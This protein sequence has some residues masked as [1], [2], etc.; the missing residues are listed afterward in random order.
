MDIPLDRL[1][2]ADAG[3][4]VAVVEFSGGP[5]IPIPI[6]L[7]FIHTLALS[8]RETVLARKVTPQ[9]LYVIEDLESANVKRF[10]YWP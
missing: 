2:C 8:V 10:S 1:D 5:K 4:Y 9:L 3:F 7:R 6:Y